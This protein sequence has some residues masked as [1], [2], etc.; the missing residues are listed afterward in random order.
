MIALGIRKIRL[1]GGEPLLRGDLEDIVAYLGTFREIQDL[2][3]TTN[4]QGL[5]RRAAALKKAG[6]TRVN[7]SLD[8][9][10]PGRY[11]ELTGGGGLEETLAGIRAALAWGLGPVK[12]NCVV[13][14][15]RNDDEAGAFIALAR[16]QPLHVRFIE[17][18]PFGER[19][20]EKLRVVSAELLA[21]HGELYELGPDT[22]GGPGGGVA[23]VYTGRGFRGTVGFISPMSRC[24]CPL[25]N[26]VRITADGKLKTCLGDNAELDLRNLLD[27]PD[28]VLRSA[29]EGEIVKKPRGHHFGEGFV[30]RR[31]MNRIGG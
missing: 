22:K 10:K 17:L 15:G 21:S 16:E 30:S 28:T 31:A 26:R 27:G 1:T 9:L 24:F 5:D 11:R 23:A 8:S 29:I 13:L 3:M 20:A 4:G 14:R 18:M 6:L 7:I 2:A 25:C 19:S 12:L